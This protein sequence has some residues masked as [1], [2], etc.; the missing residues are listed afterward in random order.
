MNLDLFEGRNNNL[1]DFI[2]ELQSL[3]ENMKGRNTKMEEKNNDLDE[4]NLYE[5]RKL[6]LDNKSRNGN[7]LAWV[8]D[9]NSV[10]ISE[11][12]DGGPIAINQINLPQDKRVGG[13]Y[14]KIDGQYV[15]NQDIT[16]KINSIIKS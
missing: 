11:N 9:E 1:A 2:N 7:D 6:F 8:M 13:V 4:Y 3:L 14:E 5:K 10:C 12:G 15:Y 16:E